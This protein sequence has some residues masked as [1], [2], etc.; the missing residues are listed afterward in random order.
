[1]LNYLGTL[2]ML[3]Q[4]IIIFGGLIFGAVI[5]IATVYRFVK[6][7]LK[8]KAGPIEIDATEENEVKEN[9]K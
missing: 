4:L 2:P 7:G 3:A 9:G 6:Y 5:I 1:M 8:I